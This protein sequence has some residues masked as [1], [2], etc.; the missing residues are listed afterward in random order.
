MFSARI[1]RIKKMGLLKLN[2]K[3]SKNLFF[4]FLLRILLDDWP[5]G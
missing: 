1:N 3:F 5:I 2:P 4:G